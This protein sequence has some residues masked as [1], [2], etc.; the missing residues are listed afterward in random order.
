MAPKIDNE[1]RNQEL[2]QQ[3][4]SD[5]IEIALDKIKSARKQIADEYEIIRG[6]SGSME[7]YLGWRI[8]E[9]KSTVQAEAQAVISVAEAMA[10]EHDED[11]IPDFVETMA[12]LRDLA[13]KCSS[14]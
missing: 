5:L 12:Q 3:Q 9:M 14:W 11:G 2:R 4:N 1:Q 13:G 7:T 8:H 6:A 10:K